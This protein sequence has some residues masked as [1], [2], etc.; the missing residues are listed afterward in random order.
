MKDKTSKPQS[1]PEGSPARKVS[2]IVPDP[3]ALKA[4]AHPDRLRML[5]ILRFSGPDTATGLAR[6]MGLNSG[7]T[8]YHL[9]QLA[10][11]GF[12]E[13]VPGRGNK[14]E[15]WWRAGHETTVYDPAEMSGEGLEAGLAMIQA[16]VSQHAVMMQR[17]LQQFPDQPEEW[18]KAS[19]A[20]DY[21]FLMTAAEAEALKDKLTAILWE[22]MRTSPAGES[23]PEGMRK[24]TVLLHSF[25]F[26][27]FGDTRPAADE[28]EG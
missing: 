18:R 8:S 1:P 9:R 3:T 12:I 25:P 14:R 2:N 17:A 10:Q 13:P 7:A 21:T 24:F 27:G 6:K 20:S 28:E 19:N 4:L 11:H 15:R 22:A 26:P 16:V 5:G 23:V